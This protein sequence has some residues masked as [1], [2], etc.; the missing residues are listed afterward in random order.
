[1][2]EWKQE[3]YGNPEHGEAYWHNGTHYV[4]FIY[5][6]GEEQAFVEAKG[7]QVLYIT[8]EADKHIAFGELS[9]EEKDQT[10]AYFLLTG[11]LP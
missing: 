1:M 3:T 7:L 8:G 10:I 6:T 9:S 4:G 5:L 11:E 2:S